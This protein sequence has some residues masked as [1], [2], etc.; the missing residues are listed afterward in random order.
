MEEPGM[1]DEMGEQER[2]ALGR[3]EAIVSGDGSY[4]QTAVP[5]SLSDLSRT[6]SRTDRE[7]IEA[8]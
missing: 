7:A 6:M 3:I 2:A 4:D 5:I 8:A 1:G